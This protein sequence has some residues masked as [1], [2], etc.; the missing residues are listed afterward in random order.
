MRSLIYASVTTLLA[1]KA[2]ATSACPIL[3]GI[4][5]KENETYEFLPKGSTPDNPNCDSFICH[6]DCDDLCQPI[7]SCPTGSKLGK[8]PAYKDRCGCDHCLND[9]GE[10]MDLPY[11]VR[12]PQTCDKASDMNCGEGFLVE[13]YHPRGEYGEQPCCPEYHCIKKSSCYH[14]CGHEEIGM[15]CHCDYECAT[16]GDCCLDIDLTCPALVD[17]M[18]REG[19]WKSLP[20]PS[21]SVAP[22]E[23]QQAGGVGIGTLQGAIA[24]LNFPIP[25]RCSGYC[26]TFAPSGCWCDESC[27]LTKDC[28]PH[29]HDVCTYFAQTHV[30]PPRPPQQ[31]K[32]AGLITFNKPVPLPT[33][34][35]NEASELS[36]SQVFGQSF[37][38]S[39]QFVGCAGGVCGKS[40]TDLNGLECFCDDQCHVKND[41]CW[42]KVG[43]CGTAQAAQAAQATQYVPYVP[44]VEVVQQAQ[45]ATMQY[46]PE[47]VPATWQFQSEVAANPTQV[48]TSTLMCKNNCGGSGWYNGKKCFC[49]P[50]CYF[51]KDCCPDFSISC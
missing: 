12:N 19:L 23:K 3:S 18:K 47:T 14:A 2:S 42:N 28:C 20:T 25:Y 15:D 6:L 22:T 32:P 9:A 46:Q 36:K 37:G 13:L 45:V 16:R 39:L 48:A 24:G 31:V 35:K 21:P 10:R 8:M 34:S 51:K 26:G 1:A 4:C 11:C 5:E 41:C 30:E 27:V 49:D 7:T 44:V 33:G 17:E 38:E 40:G 50:M 29:Y 43:V